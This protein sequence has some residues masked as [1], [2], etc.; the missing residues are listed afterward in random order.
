[1]VLAARSY[2]SLR[3][4]VLSIEEM[5][6]LAARKGHKVLGLA[7]INN[8][9]GVFDFIKSCTQNM[10]KPLVGMEFQEHDQFLYTI[11]V[12]NH[13][14]FHEMNRLYSD[15]Q[16]QAHEL[17]KQAP[18]C[19][20]YFVI[21]DVHNAPSNLNSNE[22]VGIRSYELSK[23]YL[24]IQ[25]FDSKKLLILHQPFYNSS[26]QFET[27]IH[28]RAVHFNTLL[29]HLKDN[30]TG[31]RMEKIPDAASFE[32]YFSEYPFLLENTK[33]LANLCHFDFDFMQSKNLQVFG[34]SHQDDIIMLKNYTYAGLNYRYGKNNTQAVMRIE[35]ELKTIIELGF[36]SY[37]LIT[38][39][40]IR[41]AQTQQIPHVGRG[42]GANSI[43]AYCLGITDVDPLELDLYFERF[44]NPKRSTPPD[45][46]IDFSWKDR[47]HI[48]QYIFTKYGQR[49]ALL[50][51]SNTFKDRSIIRELAKVYG[52][53]KEEIDLLIKQ[54][55]N[56]GNN[57][58]IAHKINAL[59]DEIRDFPNIRSIHAGGILI[60]NLP[61]TYF[62]ALDMPPK[63]FPTV[64]WDMY[65][66]EDIHLEKLDI[67][68]QRGL[69][70]IYE[71][72]EMVAQN[73]EI[74]IDIHDTARFKKDP[75]INQLL[76]IGET[77]GAFY[78]ESPAMRGLLKKL[79]CNNYITLVA[80]SSII[81]PGVA[82]SGMMKEY[83]KRYHHPDKF[84]YLHTIIKEQL[85]ET[86]GIMVYQEDVLKIC[87]HY[88][89]LELADAD[90]LRRL[91]TGKSR[92]KGEFERIKDSFFKNSAAKG[93]PEHV[94]MELW[95]QIESFAGY[96]FSKAH[97]ASYAVE[98]YQS[99][100]LKAYY[101]LEF[102]V[103]V[104]NNF[105][106]F[107]SRFVYFNEAKRYGAKLEAPDINFSNYTTRLIGSKVYI[108]FIHMENLEQAF[109]K[110]MIDERER[111]GY[112]DS[113]EHFLQRI[114]AGKEQLTLLIRIGAF[115]F[116]GESK[117]A[118]LWKMNFYKQKQEKS[119]PTQNTKELFNLPYKKFTLPQFKQDKLSNA[120]D[121]IEILGFPVEL[122]FFDLLENKYTGEILAQDMLNNTG[123]TVVM[124][125]I[126]IHIKGVRMSNGKKMNFGSFIDTDGNYFDT[127]HFA[128][129]LQKYPFSGFGIYALKGKIIKE[130]EQAILDVTIM[131]KMNLI[132]DKRFS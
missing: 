36:T 74:K 60:S 76:A 115:R 24:F 88:A 78:I 51:T 106:G 31:K 55:L 39:D 128:V 2:Y 25:K 41:Y 85:S 18:F 126:L 122:S 121:E 29:T 69:G 102:I 119:R 38:H 33:E 103:A 82:K 13:Q 63:G 77:I 95:R 89:G 9:S 110:Q 132:A 124:A 70:H 4:G 93:Y 72:V 32:K 96:S 28:L 54:P 44:I 49:A 37:F 75:R 79:R 46:D 94:S 107:Y 118:L 86:F 114:N 53:P 45:F 11:L 123:K 23:M 27:H 30:Q 3:F 83:I 116:T 84:E 58:A 81:R 40:I 15:A 90:V 6:T 62:S 50:G 5:V 130:F 16:I 97:S 67:L 65:V 7:D 10:I 99:L 19:E 48:T 68:S 113:F 66:A 20:H 125:G 80:A 52:L 56:P 111:N 100:F 17:P 8:T 26:K 73:Q 64:Q 57:Y 1:M 14:G 42:S 34:E 59:A 91:M 21:Y 12:K 127:T 92:Q 101:P 105:G 47:E 71:A 98:S 87:H 131:K 129:S 112:F 120:F 22:Y 43:V 117:S 35:K 108:G 104:I 61:I 109:C